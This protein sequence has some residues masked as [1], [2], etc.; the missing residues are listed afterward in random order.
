MTN[1]DLLP[2]FLEY[3]IGEGITAFSTMR[4]GGVSEGAYS[5]FNI[6]HYCGDAP[7]SVEQNRQLLCQKLGIHNNC[8]HLPRQTHS[9][10]VYRIEDNFLKKNSEERQA[11]LEGVDALITNL[12]GQCI[13][14]STADC[15]PI[16]LYDPIHQAIAAI[17]AGWRGTVA[18]IVQKTI[19]AMTKAFGS[20]AENLKAIIGPGIS[21]A[22]FEV[23]NEVYEAFQQ[24][25]FPMAE[26]ATQYKTPQSSK[27]HID[28]WAANFIQL[29]EVGLPLASIQVSGICTFTEHD[30]F[31]S[32]RRLGIESGRIFNGIMLR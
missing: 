14:I 29:E 15:I 27:W 13:G 3:H 12:R 4:E 28:L 30:R 32:A 10:V 21:Q 7:E 1:E 17:H 24:A 20:E 5:H 31:F 26:I 19:A 22:A 25:R 9:D 2:V 6:T 16:L 18:R 23:G 11:L 8:L